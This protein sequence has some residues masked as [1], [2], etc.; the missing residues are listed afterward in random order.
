[1]RRN[2]V[3]RL[4]SLGIILLPMTDLHSGVQKM[5]KPHGSFLRNF[6][7][8]YVLQHAFLTKMMRNMRNNF[9]YWKCRGGDVLCSFYCCL[10]H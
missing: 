2:M 3:Q 6:M 10:R 7:D 5:Q 1:M 8:V 9:H 4:S